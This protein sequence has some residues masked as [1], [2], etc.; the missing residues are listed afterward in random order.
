MCRLLESCRLHLVLQSPASFAAQV[1]WV[2]QW[3]TACQPGS[4]SNFSWFSSCSWIDCECL[5]G[6][7]SAPVATDE[8]APCFEEAL[9]KS[10]LDQEAWLC[11]ATNL[12]PKL[13]TSA[14]SEG[15]VM[16]S[17]CDRV[18]PPESVWICLDEKHP[19]DPH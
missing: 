15:H 12:S 11:L 14:T 5:W 18:I 3:K 10:L 19:T 16:E 4:T 17:Y 13:M 7:L 8:L 2:G 1:E 9:L 6:A